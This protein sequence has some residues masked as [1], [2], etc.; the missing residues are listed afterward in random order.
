MVRDTFETRSSDTADLER[1]KQCLDSFGECSVTE[2]EELRDELH[3][4]RL[5]S[6]MWSSSQGGGSLRGIDDTE[7][8]Q[9]RRLEEELNFQLHMLQKLEGD[10]SLKEK[11][12]SATKSSSLV[13]PDGDDSMIAT[14]ETRMLNLNGSVFEDLAFCAVLAMAV[15]LPN[16]G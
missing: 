9:H 15:L 16:L 4:T 13:E 2:M 7:I 6:M 11:L 5:K 8:R 10:E 3:D 12:F 1:A 14:T